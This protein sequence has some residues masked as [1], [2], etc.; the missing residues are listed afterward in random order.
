MISYHSEDIA[1]SLKSKMLNNRWVKAVCENERKRLGDVAFIF[2][3]DA[4]ILEVNKEYLGHDYFTDIITFDYCEDGRISGDLFISVDTVRDNAAYYGV[5]FDTELDR[6]MV[7]GIL[8]LVGYDD[9]AEEDV[10]IM[11]SKE[12]RYIALKRELVEKR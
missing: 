2:C 7:H 3:S 4:R 12:D 11:R 9:H 1:F 8:H 5:D 10:K 6:V